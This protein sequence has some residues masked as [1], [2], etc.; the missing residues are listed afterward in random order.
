MNLIYSNNFKKKKLC[1]D[2]N[3]SNEYL[4]KKGKEVLLYNY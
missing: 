3:I 1:Y 4:L 2:F